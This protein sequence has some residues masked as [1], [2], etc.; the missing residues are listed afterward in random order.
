MI[1]RKFVTPAI[2]ITPPSTILY[3]M[4]N[5]KPIDSADAEVIKQLGL[6]STP[7]NLLQ[8]INLLTAMQG[9]TVTEQNELVN[10]LGIR[11]ITKADSDLSKVSIT[12]AD[13]YK[14]AYLKFNET[15]NK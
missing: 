12:K 14:V 5:N 13:L 4:D 11:V 7:T 2:E 3:T 15:A 9:K 6:E 1:L 8:L 10:S